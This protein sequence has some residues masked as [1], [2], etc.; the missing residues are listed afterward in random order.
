M[1]RR[2]TFALTTV[3]FF[4]HPSMLAHVLIF[5]NIVHMIYMGQTRPH[6]TRFAR[7]KDVFNESCLQAVSVLIGMIPVTLTSE[8]ESLVG[9]FVIQVI[10]LV[11]FVNLVVIFVLGV[12][13]VKRRLRLKKLKQRRL[14]EHTE[15]LDK[16]KKTGQEA[17]IV[18]IGHVRRAAIDDSLENSNQHLES[19]PM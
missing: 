1:F 13:D 15:A 9:W 8:D 12:L 6:I 11:F 17:V 5:M 18:P 10:S 4:E 7:V 14:K 2:L 19:E 16:R 3:F